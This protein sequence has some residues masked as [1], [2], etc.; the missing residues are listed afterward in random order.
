M[1]NVAPEVF[2]TESADTFVE[3][4]HGGAPTHSEPELFGLAPFQIVSVAM[5]VLLLIAFFG[6]KVH[7][8]IGRQDRRHQGA[9]RR[10]ETTSRRSRNAAPGICGQDRRRR[11][12][13]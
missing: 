5:F 12:G 13:R 11:K 8:S 9:A 6:A 2:A 1:A 10:G 4:G 7:K 3:A